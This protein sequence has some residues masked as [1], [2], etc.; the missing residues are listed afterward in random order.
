[1][2]TINNS[3]NN[4]VG[5]SNSGVTNTFTVTNPSNTA[6]SQALVNVK[7]GGSTAGDPF[8]TYTVTGVTDWSVG[9]DNSDSDAFVLSASAALGTTNVIR[10]STAGQI[11]YPLQPAFLAYLNTGVSNVTG[12]A[13]VYT[14]I[15]DTEVFDIGSNFN[16]GTSTFTAPVTGKYLLS[17]SVAAIGTGA[18]S[19]C[20]MRI[21]TTQRTYFYNLGAD[22]GTNLRG[23]QYATVLA[24]MNATDTATFAVQTTDAS[25]KQTAILGATGGMQRTIVSGHLVC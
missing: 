1:M 11:N 19:G 24:D 10:A 13:T 9:L 25:G 5:A 12:D 15:F 17:L 8:A 20:D 6:S 3:I 21:V 18:L 16:L 23:S 4:I 2:V 14:I 22:P 7:V